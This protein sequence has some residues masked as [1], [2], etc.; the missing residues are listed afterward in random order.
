MSVRFV[1]EGDY[2]AVLQFYTEFTGEEYTLSKE[3]FADYINTTLQN[4]HMI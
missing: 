1:Q 3:V 2:A 4:H